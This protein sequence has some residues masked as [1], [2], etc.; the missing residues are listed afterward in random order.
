MTLQDLVEAI[1]SSVATAQNEIEKQNIQNISSYFD[2]DGNPEI[3]RIKIPTQ[4][5]ALHQGSVD[6]DGDGPGYE[7]VEIPL[8]TLLQIN[9]IKIKEMSVEF[10]ISLN[11]VEKIEALSDDKTDDVGNNLLQTSTSEEIKKKRNQK[12]MSTD[13]FGDRKNRNA[14][15]NI[16]FES[17]EPPEGYLK[18]NSHL[19]KL[20]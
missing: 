4:H 20:F 7:E 11:T 15:V 2:K 8:F 17:G 10:D 16:T 14:K 12:I 9:P 13:L 6:H 19:M 18:L 5:E 3:V 1:L